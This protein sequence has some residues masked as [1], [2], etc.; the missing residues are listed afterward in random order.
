M[1]TSS[2]VRRWRDGNGRISR[3][4][5]SL[6]LAREG[7]L[8]PAFVSI[9]EYLGRHT[10]EYYA[11]L[12]QIQGGQY[13]PARDASAW[14]AFCVEAHVAQA[15]QRLAQLEGG[16]ARWA[17]FEE[18]VASRGW[19]DRLVIALDQSALGGTDRSLYEREADVSPATASNDVRRLLD[20]GLVTQRGRG[21]STRYFASDS[22]LHRLDASASDHE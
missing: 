7:L 12:Q 14:V 3:L 5:Q 17:V 16:A 13:Q 6:V 11:V 18:L 1:H 20:A 21:R 2:C 22:L 4:V 9:E 15:R 8:A 19:P 10:P